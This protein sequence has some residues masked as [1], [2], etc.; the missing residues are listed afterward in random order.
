MSKTLQTVLKRDRERYKIP[1][2]VQDA[3]PIRR[4]WAEGVFQFGRK[5]YKTI[6]FSDIN[7]TIASKADKTDM[8]LDDQQLLNRLED[9]WGMGLPGAGED[10]PLT[11]EAVAEL[12]PGAITA[13][14]HSGEEVTLEI[15]WDL[16]ALPEES[17]SDG[18]YILTAALPEA[19]ALTEEAAALTITLPIGGPATYTVT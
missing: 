3:I 4:I 1:R 8:F 5:F 10:T 13:M 12:L 9:G 14:T 16:T 6:R 19:Y 15:S 11:R 17:I 2:S 7:Y 18:D